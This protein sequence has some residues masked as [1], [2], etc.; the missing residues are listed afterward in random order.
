M[1]NQIRYFGRLV[2]PGSFSRGFG[3]WSIIIHVLAWIRL[4]AEQRLVL[5]LLRCELLRA[6]TP[7]KEIAKILRMARLDPTFDPAAYHELVAKAKRSFFRDML[8]EQLG[9]PRAER[10]T[11]ERKNTPE[12]PHYARPG[13]FEEG[14]KL[15]LAG[16]QR[17]HSRE[18]RYVHGRKDYQVMDSDGDFYPTEK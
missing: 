15:T 8:S 7:K 11:E 13:P 12:R 17:R 3:F 5:L 4:W 6:G 16:Y 9:T 14:A 18:A 10:Y 2:D 1:I